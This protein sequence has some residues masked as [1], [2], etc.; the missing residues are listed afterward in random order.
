MF[1]LIL[2]WAFAAVTP[3]IMAKPL[4]LPIKA[5]FISC[6]P[7]RQTS[8]TV[9][10]GSINTCKFK[11]ATP[12]HRGLFVPAAK[13]I[14][15]NYWAEG[16][17]LHAAWRQIDRPCTDQDRGARRRQHLQASG[18]SQS[19]SVFAEPASDARQVPLSTRVRTAEAAVADRSCRHIF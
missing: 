14:A 6:P 12:P 8:A 18:A 11:E 1:G 13:K 5:S 10:L 2:A 3:T 4:K 17:D 19:N 7:F 15:I 9:L 16:T